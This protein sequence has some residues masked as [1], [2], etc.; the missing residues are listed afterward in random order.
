MY[1]KNE[2]LKF[3]AIVFLFSL[4]LFFVFPF[5][6]FAVRSV[7]DISVESAVTYDI[8]TVTLS[9]STQYKVFTLKGPDRL[10]LE[11][12]DCEY[13][14]TRKPI[15]MNT[16]FIKSIHG[17]QYREAPVKKARV[18]IDVKKE[19][20]Y[21]AEMADN[22]ILLELTEK[23]GKSK[24]ID[25][26]SLPSSESGQN[27]SEST[28]T[29]QAGEPK[30]STSAEQT[31]QKAA[32]KPAV[33]AKKVKKQLKKPVIAKKKGTVAAVP[34]NKPANIP[35][36]AV[37]VST[38]PAKPGS[39]TKSTETAAGKIPT[40]KVETEKQKKKPAKKKILPNIPN[41]KHQ[42]L[43]K[44]AR[45]EE[46]RQTVKKDLIKPATQTIQAQQPSPAVPVKGTESTVQQQESKKDIV[47]LDFTDA[48][49]RDVFQVLAIKKGVNIICG[50]DVIGNVSIHLENV[51][52]EEAMDIILK[53]K[54]RVLL[55]HEKKEGW[56]RPLPIYAARCEEHGLYEDY[57]HGWKKE[58]ECPLCLFERL[59]KACQGNKP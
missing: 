13:P 1:P 56:S 10:V 18:V 45:E 43:L 23:S 2:N 50:D 32:A 55:R 58:L 3:R 38:V 25:Q 53:M 44:Q 31:T 47:T 57:P 12:E 34:K 51:P 7:S 49:I 54:G 28:E 17:G 29:T 26:E 16:K 21:S 8:V 41:K 48:D 14:K 40:A 20:N 36:S 19:I 9:S 15:L 4:V 39:V 30:I 24:E 11:L 6:V 46:N 33:Q 27:I 35:A 42:K 37:S 59:R 5:K 22:Q 52:F